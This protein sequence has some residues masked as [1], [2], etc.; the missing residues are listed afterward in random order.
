MEIGA[1]SVTVCHLVN[2]AY[3]HGQHLKWDPAKNRFIDKTG[4]K[5]W[6]DIPH[7]RPWTV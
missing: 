6:L 5:D 4:S 2:L 7:R 3:Y 1:R